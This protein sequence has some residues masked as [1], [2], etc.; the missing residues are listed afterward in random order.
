M[1]PSDTSPIK[2]EGADVDGADHDG[3]ERE[4]GSIES[5]RN[6]ASLRFTVAKSMAHMYVK[7]SDKGKGTEE[8]CRILM[9]AEGK[10]SLSQ[11]AES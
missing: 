8:W 10:I 11:D 7:G 5:C 9:I 1:S 2:E 6:L 4:G 3:V